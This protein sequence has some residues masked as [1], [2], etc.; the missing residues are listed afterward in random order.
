[1]EVAMRAI[2]FVLLML[3]FAAAFMAARYLVPHQIDGV[4]VYVAVVLVGLAAVGAVVGL[5]TG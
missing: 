1:L 5:V 2:Q 3:G 4:A